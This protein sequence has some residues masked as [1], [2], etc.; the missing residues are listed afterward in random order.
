MHRRR[1]ASHVAVAATALAVAAPL[2][3]GC[4]SEETRAGAAAVVDGER[5]TVSQ[6]QS[7]SEA[8]RDAQRAG[9]GAGELIRSSGRLGHYNLNE[10]ISSR[11]IARAAADEGVRVSRRE[12]QEA[13]AS[14]QKRAGG[15]EQ[16]ESTLLREN[17]LAPSQ[18]NDSYRTTLLFNK[19]V[20]ALGV[21]AGDP[22]ADEVISAKLVETSKKMGIKVSPR[23]G[24]W[25]ME[26]FQ[27]ADGE[28]SWL[29][30]AVEKEPGAGGH[31]PEDGHDHG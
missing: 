6:V 7:R 23:Y 24:S 22:K 1:S 27:L 12:V 16:L 28:R 18:I 31:G 25:D 30:A 4:G 19:L 2:L 9:D 11:V 3:T 8:V 5:I 20:Q 26:K 15:K 17:A 13:R 29:K 21:Q 14:D 10:M